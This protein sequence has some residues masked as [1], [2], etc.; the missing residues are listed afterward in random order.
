MLEAIASTPAEARPNQH[1]L[2]QGYRDSYIPDLMVDYRVAADRP[3]AWISYNFHKT[4]PSVI[5]GLK[6]LMADELFDVPQA[7]LTAVALHDAFSW[8]YAHF[9]LEDEMPI[10][11]ENPAATDLTRLVLHYAAAVA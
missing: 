11:A 5:W 10:V 7:G 9:I 1:L 3:F 4:Y 8:A 2:S 6:L